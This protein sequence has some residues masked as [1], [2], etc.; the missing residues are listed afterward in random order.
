[1]ANIARYYICVQLKETADILR[2]AGLIKEGDDPW[3]LGRGH[4]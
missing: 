2:D 3:N 4:Q 1:M